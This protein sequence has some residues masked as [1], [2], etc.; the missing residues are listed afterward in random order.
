M[1]LDDTIEILARTPLLGLL[2]R[3]ALRLVAFS[4]EVRRL[5]AGE[6]LFRQAERSDGGYVVLSGELEASRAGSDDVIPAGPGSLIGRVAL[7]LRL[8]REASVRA[9]ERSAVLRVSPTLMRRVL[10]EFPQAASQIRD[11]VAADLDELGEGLE[12]VRSL[13]L[14]LDRPR[15]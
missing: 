6:F 2:E 10:E 12:R 15:T 13:L 5:A 3:D 9:R 4:A 11:A 8:P 1:A 14:S 7:F